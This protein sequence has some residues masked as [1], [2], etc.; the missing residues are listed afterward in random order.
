MKLKKFILAALSAAF[1][2]GAMTLSAM[3]AEITVN[4]ADQLKA[5]LQNADYDTITLGGDITCTSDQEILR[6]LTLDLGDHTLTITGTTNKRIAINVSQPAGEESQDYFAVT[7]KNGNI[8]G[9]LRVDGY[10]NTNL[11]LEKINVT[12]TG[13]PQAVNAV[14]KTSTVDIKSGTFQSDNATPLAASKSGQYRL[15]PGVVCIST[16]T[17]PDVKEYNYLSTANNYVALLPD[18]YKVQVTEIQD[19]SGSVIGKRMEV[20]PGESAFI[21]GS[22]GQ[23]YT[24]IEAAIGA[25]VT[26]ITFATDIFST[27]KVVIK[28]G[29]EININPTDWDRQYCGDIENHGILKIHLRNGAMLGEITNVEPGTI[30]IDRSGCYFKT[31][32]SD[33]AGTD[34]N[35]NQL[36]AE[37]D[38]DTGLWK[39]DTATIHGED[40]QIYSTIAKAIAAGNKNITLQGNHSENIVINVTEPVTIDL[41]GHTLS[42]G[43]QGKYATV[44]INEGANVKIVNNGQKLS[45]GELFSKKSYYQAKEHAIENH[46]T[47]TLEG[48]TIRGSDAR[49]Y[50]SNKSISQYALVRSDG[51]LTITGCDIENSLNL[52]PGG[53]H[54][55]IDPDI[56]EPDCDGGL[57]VLVYGGNATITNS[58][59]YGGYNGVAVL[60]NGET[61]MEAK[62]VS[63][64]EEPDCYTVITGSSTSVSYSENNEF[65][66]MPGGRKAASVYASRP[67]IIDIQAGKYNSNITDYTHNK[68]VSLGGDGYYTVTPRT[69]ENLTND[70]RVVFER[71]VNYSDPNEYDIILESA[72]TTTSIYR[73]MAA[74]LA[75]TNEGSTGTTFEITP[76]ENIDMIKPAGGLNGLYE[77]NYNGTDQQSK[78]GRIVLAKVRFKGIGHVAFQVDDKADNQV[79]TAV[80]YSMNEDKPVDDNIVR[81]YKPTD[82]KNKLTIDPNYK[83]EDLQYFTYGSLGYE[84]YAPTVPVN[85]TIDYN[86]NITAGN[87]ADYNN[88]TVELIGPTQTYVGKV[89]ANPNPD[90]TPTPVAPSPEETPEPLPEPETVYNDTYTANQ[91]VVAFP[92][93]EA[94]YNY[95]LKVSG[96]GYRTVYDSIYVPIPEDNVTEPTAITRHFWNNVDDED[97]ANFLAGDIDNSQKVDLYDLSAAVAYFGKTEMKDEAGAP[98]EANDVYIRYD[99]NRDGKIDSKDIAMVLVSWGY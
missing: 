91:A 38:D 14:T 76:S 3:A 50:G 20:V 92:G 81:T 95:T 39:V 96:D 53:A 45:D 85:V 37:F 28:E 97:G 13:S 6:A 21:Q 69:V 57:G 17:K 23:F 24:S 82:D 9:S 19:D 10:T 4:D 58:R 30:L 32:V 22:D 31:D 93:V 61:D 12:A 56:I 26:D 8:N 25:G 73:F 90:P 80:F 64:Q 98:T 16:T 42:G 65:A 34:N 70:I 62:T 86:N 79:Q 68:N 35:N 78:D 72:N 74:Q 55:G 87:R 2:F 94:G 44:T 51:D 5:A 48:L 43:Q 49:P 41:N 15:S 63:L 59:I 66:P 18:G 60:E 71:S 7:I 46:G 75:F 54:G 84:I 29:E 88:M 11:I 89:G 67:E 1:V 83:R 47:L 99:L 27:K 77:F 36:G 52:E 40:E 33:W